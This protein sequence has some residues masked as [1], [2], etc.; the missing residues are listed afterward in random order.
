MMISG[1]KT[2]AVFDRYNIVSEGDLKEAARK[3][4][5]G[6]QEEKAKLIEFDQSLAKVAPKSVQVDKHNNIN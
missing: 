5:Q 6:A 1:H 4:E 3:I 2:R